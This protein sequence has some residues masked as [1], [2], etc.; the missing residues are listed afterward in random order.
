[1][2]LSWIWAAIADG[3]VVGGDESPKRAVLIEELRGV[4]LATLMAVVVHQVGLLWMS[5]VRKRTHIC[6]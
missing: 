6:T 4:F 2:R 5:P 1:M 3:E